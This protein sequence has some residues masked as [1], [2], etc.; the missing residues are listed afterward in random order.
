[1]L[2]NDVISIPI[3]LL[4]DLILEEALPHLRDF[5]SEFIMAKNLRE[6]NILGEVIL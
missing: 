5:L 2:S 6:G 4:Y 3:Q 1:M